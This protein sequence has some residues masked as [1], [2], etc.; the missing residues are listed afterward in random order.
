LTL[1]AFYFPL[2]AFQ[3]PHHNNSGRFLLLPLQCVKGDSS[4]FHIIP[5]ASPIAFGNQEG[6]QIQRIRKK[7]GKL[8]LI[9]NSILETGKWKL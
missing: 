2:A 4:R 3:W 6:Q 8:I 5:S 7:G 9:G 1:A